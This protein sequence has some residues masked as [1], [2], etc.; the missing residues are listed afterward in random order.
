MPDV[1]SA[2]FATQGGE[3]NKMGG[4]FADIRPQ[5]LHDQEADRAAIF[6]ALGT[7]KVNMANDPGGQDLGVVL[8]SGHGAMIDGHF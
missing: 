8:F 5:Y 3:F 4:L 2:L 1:A 6:R 7:M